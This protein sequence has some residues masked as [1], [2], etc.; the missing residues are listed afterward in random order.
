MVQFDVGAIVARYG[1]RAGVIEVLVDRPGRLV[2]RVTIGAGRALAVKVDDDPSAFVPERASIGKLAAHGL[3]VPAILGFSDLP[4]AHLVLDWIPG[5]PLSSRSAPA[6]QHAAGRLLRRVHA[7]PGG[8]PYAGNADI[9]D[10][11][12]GWLNVAVA[13]WRSY[14]D[15]GSARVDALWRWY[16][17]LRPL[18]QARGGQT[19]LFDGR[20][21]HF[22][23]NG[24]DVVGL[25]D[26]HD[27]TSGDAAMDLA[28]MGVDD[29]DLIAGVLAGYRLTGAE[30]IAYDRLIPFYLLVRRLAAAEWHLRCG[31]AARTPAMLDLV[32]SSAIPDPPPCYLLCGLT[33]SGKTTYARQIESVG[34]VRLSVDEEVFARNGRYGVDYPDHEYPARERPVV[35]ELRARMAALIRA[36]RPVVFDW[37]LWRRADRDAYKRLVTDS[38]GRWHLLYFPADREVLRRRLAERNRRADPNALTVTPAALDEFISRFEPPCGEGEQIIDLI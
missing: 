26:L 8:P 31:D 6:A 2:A 22:I 20:P 14:D 30:R 28:V 12:A 18:L 7:L 17:R 29:L 33:G 4:P 23:V 15:P 13:W 35:A 36:G 24:D 27:V 10:W 21:E 5:E 37:G 3:P 9:A 11:M 38:G 16:H 32:R 34:A 19:T 25:I 1:Y